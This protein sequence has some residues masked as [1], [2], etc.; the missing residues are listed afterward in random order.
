MALPQV[1]D[2]VRQAISFSEGF[3]SHIASTSSEDAQSN[4]AGD[5]FVYV[6]KM[7]VTVTLLGQNFLSGMVWTKGENYS[8][9]TVL[10]QRQ[11]WHLNTRIGEQK[12]GTQNCYIVNKHIKRTK[13][14]NQHSPLA[15]LYSLKRELLESNFQ[16]EERIFSEH[17]LDDSYEEERE[18]F[19]PIVLGTVFLLSSS[20]KLSSVGF[21]S[22][23]EVICALDFSVNANDRNAFEIKISSIM[24]DFSRAIGRPI[25]INVYEFTVDDLEGSEIFKDKEIKDLGHNITQKKA[26]R[27][28]YLMWLGV[29]SG[30]VALFVAFDMSGQSDFEK[31]MKKQRII[32]RKAE[33]KRIADE[34]EIER[35]KDAAL[36]FLKQKLVSPQLD[37]DKGLLRALLSD[38][39]T[40]PW[41]VS[42]NTGINDNWVM[43]E[44]KCF[45][46]PTEVDSKAK[47]IPVNC[48]VIFQ[49]QQRSDADFLKKKLDQTSIKG[50][51]DLTNEFKRNEAHAVFSYNIPTMGN[52]LIAREKSTEA[53]RF[54]ESLL[55]VSD[56]QGFDFS[57]EDKRN[58][59][60][61]DK[62]VMEGIKL[63][64]ESKSGEITFKVGSRLSRFKNLKIELPLNSQISSITGQGMTVEIKGG[65][66]YVK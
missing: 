2:N 65:Y 62:D 53:I 46:N 40:L 52:S 18:V 26:N 66:S 43:N 30:V 14:L 3:V 17:E 7:T 15:S 64:G 61:K 49:G 4:F 23:G 48:K 20:D 55:S 6:G 11:Y 51:Y 10:A 45:S 16:C 47:T 32:E 60:S 12:L 25:Q 31:R 21:S 29:A 1:I 35:K 34:K 57:Y 41:V 8:K 39:K 33:L 9:N 63:L 13:E 22:T 27:K 59:T 44:W 5:E 37:G 36:T 50:R 38:L 19:P 28:K 24:N 42:Q 56:V 54:F 58:Y